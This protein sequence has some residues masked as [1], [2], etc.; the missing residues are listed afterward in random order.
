MTF[1]DLLKDYRRWGRTSQVYS[2][3]QMLRYNMS[4]TENQCMLNMHSVCRNYNV[5]K[6]NKKENKNC[7][8]R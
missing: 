2:T 4:Y 6:Q 7:Y 5:F 8:S 3:N 1:I